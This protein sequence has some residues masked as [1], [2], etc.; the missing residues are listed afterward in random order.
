LHLY[1]RAVGQLMPLNMFTRGDSLF[2]VVTPWGRVSNWARAAGTC[3]KI[4][5]LSAI[6]DFFIMLLPS[7]KEVRFSLNRHAVLGRN[8]NVQHKKCVIGRAGTNRHLGVRPTVRGVAM[9]PVDHP[10]GGRTKTS[11]PEVSP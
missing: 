5:Y 3:G 10:H 2:G 9:N 7:G 4:R 1:S 8:S 11:K 6:R